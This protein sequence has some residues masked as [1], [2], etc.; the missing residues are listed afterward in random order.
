LDS[1]VKLKRAKRRASSSSEKTIPMNQG[2]RVVPQ[3]RSPCDA[4]PPQG[5]FALGISRN[6][7][8][9]I[10]M[11]IC[12][13]CEAQSMKARNGRPHEFLIKVDEPRIFRGIKPRGF[14]EQDYECLTCK[15]KFTHS[16]DKNGLA[17][18]LWRA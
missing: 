8:E 6:W 17:W 1:F 11:K 5:A 10:E 12:D 3:Q 16:T 2:L 14:E 4:A 18:T 13:L 7:S 15:S 9:R